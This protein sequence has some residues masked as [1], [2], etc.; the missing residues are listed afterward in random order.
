M[1]TQRLRDKVTDQSSNFVPAAA[2]G[3]AGCTDD[4]PAEVQPGGAEVVPS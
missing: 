4:R 2:E 3:V 1:G